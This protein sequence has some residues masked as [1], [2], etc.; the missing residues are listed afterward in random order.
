MTT[1]AWIITV[2]HNIFLLNVFKY[3]PIEKYDSMTDEHKAKY[4][5]E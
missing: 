2:N 3:A 1:L 5:N 4:V